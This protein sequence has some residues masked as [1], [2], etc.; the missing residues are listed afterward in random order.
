M[1]LWHRHVW[2]ESERSFFQARGGGWGTTTIITFKCS[3]NA[4]KQTRLD[5]HVKN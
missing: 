3:C 5:G 4:Y 1:K 2:L